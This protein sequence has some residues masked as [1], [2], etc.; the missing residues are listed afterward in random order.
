MAKS[1]KLHRAK[2]AKNDEFYTLLSDVSEELKHYRQHFIGKKVYC[3]CD[4]PESSAFWEYF[5]RNFGQ[6]GLDSLVSTYLGRNDDTVYRTEYAGGNDEDIKAGVKAPLEGNGDFRSQDCIELLKEA[7]IVVTN[8]P[9][10]LFREFIAQL[11]EYDKKFIII[12]NQNA[13]HYKEIF[14]LIQNNKVWLGYN[15]VKKFYKPNGMLK[16]FGNI[17]WYTNLDILKRHEELVLYRHFSE[18][19]Y[20][21]YMNFNGINVDKVSEIPCDYYG[22]MGVPDTFLEQYNPEQFE[23]CGLSTGNSA[24]AIGVQKNY[25]GSTDLAFIK[26]GK[27]SCPYSRIIIRR[28]GQK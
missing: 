21:S 11:V 8:P 20:L 15:H 17:L 18:D 3:N 4:N 10:S 25:R 23:I 22:Y 26:N 6:L 24:K 1:D 27:P 7:D 19:A 28:K 9:F 12:G 16:S 2:K 14:P 13:L 5:H